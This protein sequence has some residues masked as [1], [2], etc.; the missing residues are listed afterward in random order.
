MWLK[1]DSSQRSILSP[2]Y[3]KLSGFYSVALRLFKSHVVDFMCE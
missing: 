3:L 1:Y 2:L